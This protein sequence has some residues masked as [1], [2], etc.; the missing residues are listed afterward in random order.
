MARSAAP[1]TDQSPL[2][3]NNRRVVRAQRYSVKPM[4]I[5]EAA[6][7]LEGQKAP[8]LVFRDATTEAVSVLYRREDGQI[9]LI[10]PEA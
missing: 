5:E 9:A 7:E 3:R 4:T 6:I 10:E 1:V 8:V 2:E